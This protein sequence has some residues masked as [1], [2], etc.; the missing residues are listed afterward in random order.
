MKILIS[1]DMEGV[2]GVVTWD[3]VTPGQP[4]YQRFRRLMTS[5]VNAAVRG[6]LAGGA[7]EVCVTDGHWD[8]SNIVIEDL[9]PRAHLNAGSPSA[10]SMMQGIGEAVD[11][12]L[13]IG[14]HARQGTPNAVLDHTWSASCVHGVW[15]ND[16]PAGE[17]TLNAA[18][19][20]SF[21]VPVLLVTGDSAVCRQGT[22]LI[23]SVETVVVK[24]ATGRFAADCQPPTV[25]Q[26]LIEAAAKKAVRSLTA[27]TAPAPY[28]PELPI[29]LVV[30][31]QS[32]DMADRAAVLPGMTRHGCRLS[33]SLPDMI[34]AYGM[35][36]ALVSLARPT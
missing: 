13:F 7:Q 12:V 36:R 33:A 10:F 27:K 14:Y 2:T 1:A 26:P 17:Y 23:D 31:F 5:D 11:G 3:Q 28:Q 19:A 35:F 32:S 24:I 6:A 18:L 15:V 21:G 34:A 30:E 4:E 25:T 29:G 16:V 20:G 9:D 8:G 22:D